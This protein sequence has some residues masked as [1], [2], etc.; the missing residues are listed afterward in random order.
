M[1][2]IGSRKKKKNF[3]EFC[4]GIIWPGFK[5]Y[6]VDNRYFVSIYL[7]EVEDG[8][9]DEWHLFIEI[10]KE[11]SFSLNFQ[12]NIYRYYKD[13]PLVFVQRYYYS[14]SEYGTPILIVAENTRKLREKLKEYIP[15]FNKWHSSQLQCIPSK[16]AQ[17]N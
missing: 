11:Q 7:G 2:R 5:Y 6:K 15:K 13:S 17:R 16:I 10:K 8:T 12:N 3:D 14:N 9:I 4:I 1:S